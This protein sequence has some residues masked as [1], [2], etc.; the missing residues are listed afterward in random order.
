[1]TETI[2]KVVETVS[3]ID[4]V[5]EKDSSSSPS[6]S[7]SHSLP[8]DGPYFSPAFYNSHPVSR[9]EGPLLLHPPTGLGPTPFPRGFPETSSV[10]M[11]QGEGD[12]I[13]S[14]LTIAVKATTRKTGVLISKK[15]RNSL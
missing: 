10:I 15:T 5:F 4:K 9:F 6:S 14:V 3:K 12:E 7:A 11:A 8:G 2:K 13:I 1:M